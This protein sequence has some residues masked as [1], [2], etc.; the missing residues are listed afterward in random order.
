MNGVHVFGWDVPAE[1]VVLGAIIGA[2]YGLLAV[3][4]VLVYRSSRLVNFAHAEIG[5]FAATILYVGVNRWGL[6][7][8]L[9]L[10]VALAV[11]ALLGVGVEAIVVG[12]LNKAPALM[13]IVATL[14]VAQLLSALAAAIAAGG[15]QQFAFSSPPGMPTFD[16]GAL[17]LTGDY[18]ATLIIAPIVVAAL[19]HFL[20][21]TRSGLRVRGDSGKP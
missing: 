13:S 10:P 8:Y 15:G 6:P 7:Y 17:R 11:A 2:S 14:G 21:R 12:R 20:G 19:A 5:A 4:L 1:V 3:G 18:T 16:I 9:V